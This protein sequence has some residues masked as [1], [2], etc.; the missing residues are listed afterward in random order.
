[1]S[2]LFLRRG[3]LHRKVAAWTV[4]AVTQ[5]PHKQLPGELLLCLLENSCLR[6]VNKSSSVV[7]GAHCCQLH[8]PSHLLR[9]FIG[10]V[11]CVMNHLTLCE[12]E[13]LL[14]SGVLKASKKFS[15]K[16]SA[17]VITPSGD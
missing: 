12:W 14:L 5:K 3:E 2:R 1:M 10:K 16:V 9:W 8:S 6:L 15:F 13:C 4:T 7:S 11:N 17:L